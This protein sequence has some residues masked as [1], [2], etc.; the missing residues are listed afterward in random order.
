MS[1]AFSWSE[2]SGRCLDERFDG[3]RDYDWDTARWREFFLAAAARIRA[4][5]N[6]RTALDVGCS[7]GL[8]V[9][10]LVSVGVDAVGVDTN[11]GAVAAAHPDVRDRLRIGS[12]TDP[13]EDRYD[14]VTCV[15]VLQHLA[16]A[17][18]QLAI[19]R[20]TAAT[21]LVLFSSTPGHFEDPTHVNVRPTA[22]WVAAFAER[23]F[24]RRIDVNLDFLA[25]WAVLVQR[26]EPSPRDLV[27][28]YESQYAPL[29]A[30]VIEKRAALR[31]SHEEIARLHS[32][33]RPGDIRRLRQ[34]LASRQEQLGDLRSEL[35]AAQHDVLTTRDHIIGL[36]AKAEEAARRLVNLRERQSSQREEIEQL[37]RRVRAQRRRAEE[38][39]REVQALLASRT[40]RLGSLFTRPF[41]SG[42]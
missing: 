22:E 8:L 18:A 20:M 34:E 35:A 19:D 2:S 36:E 25:P 9:Q 33:G 24:Y 5:T 32:E 41:R 40:W 26:G 39:E 29:H 14:L 10:A 15:E 37:Q 16:P 17:Q 23:G 38:K 4:L 21:D 12:A 42:R 11:K 13:I 30:E 6:A 27:H 7:K 3:H 28:A 31:E 1:E